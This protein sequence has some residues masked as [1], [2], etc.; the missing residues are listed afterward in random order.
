[1]SKI[2]ILIA[3]DHDLILQ[4]LANLLVEEEWIAQIHQARTKTDVLRI[5][6]QEQ[7]QVL[8]Q[9]VKFGADDARSFIPDIRNKYAELKII[10]LSSLG[11]S[12]SIHSVMNAGANGYVVKSESG[13]QLVSV[14]KS[15]LSDGQAL[16]VESQKVLFKT[17]ISPDI[18]LSIREKEVLKAILEELST[19]EIAALLFLSEKTVEHY[20]ATLFVKFDVKNV[21]GLVKN[22]IL[23]GFWQD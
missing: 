16:S 2:G 22:A 5:L 11:D 15:V 19:K 1:M 20:R 13:S 10:A 3:D 14:I 21:T 9:D 6:Q 23:L 7:I 12:A 18:Q 8:I 17:Q 4:G